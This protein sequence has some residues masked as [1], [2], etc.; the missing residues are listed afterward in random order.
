MLVL[1]STVIALLIICGADVPIGIAAFV[2]L[3]DSLLILYKT[4][5]KS[6]LEEKNRELGWENKQFMDQVER[7]MNDDK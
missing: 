2:L 5:E 1:I 4:G 7:L 3:A 6:K